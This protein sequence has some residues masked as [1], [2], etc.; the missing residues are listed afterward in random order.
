MAEEEGRYLLEGQIANSIDVDG[1]N[2]KWV[3]TQDGVWLFNETG[4][5]SIRYFDRENSPLFSDE[6]RGVEVNQQTG[7]VFFGM[8]QGIVSYRSDATQGLGSL[9]GNCDNIKVFPNPVR[10]EFNGLIGIS[11]LPTDAS[12]K[13]TDIS[14]KLMYETRAEGGTAT[15]NR[16]NYEGEQA[17]TGVYM[18]FVSSRDGEQ[19]CI[20]KLTLIQ[21]PD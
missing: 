2:R 11:G 12:V 18:V 4:S 13:I 19:G 10:P 1:S 16:L 20:S 14:G 21:Q 5:R 8:N 17:R 3:A 15:W 7:E 9:Q 6:I